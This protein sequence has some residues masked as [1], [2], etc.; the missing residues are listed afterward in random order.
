MAAAEC[1]FMA[2]KEKRSPS[3]IAVA[4]ADQLRSS[5]RSETPIVVG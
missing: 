4:Q 1:R 3:L 5:I 2:L